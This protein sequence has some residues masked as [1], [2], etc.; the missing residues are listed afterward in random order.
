MKPRD[1]HKLDH[2]RRMIANLERLKLGKESKQPADPFDLPEDGPSLEM[3]R[4]LN[5]SRKGGK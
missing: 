2:V 1:Q 3:Q 5:E 4:A